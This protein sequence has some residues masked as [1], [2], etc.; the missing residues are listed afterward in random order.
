[1]T[2]IDESE[3]RKVYVSKYSYLSSRREL[4]KILKNLAARFQSYLPID[5]R[6]RAIGGVVTKNGDIHL[7]LGDYS[8]DVGFLTRIYHFKSE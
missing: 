1:M 4:S 8:D 7:V 2:G 6:A 3:V 5:I